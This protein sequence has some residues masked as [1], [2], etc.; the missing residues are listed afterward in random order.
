M[1]TSTTTSVTSLSSKNENNKKRN[2]QEDTVNG[3]KKRKIDE[4]KLITLFVK[5]GDDGSPTLVDV[6]LEGKRYIGH[7]HNYLLDALQISVSPVDVKFRDGTTGVY[8]DNTMPLSTALSNNV[9]YE[10]ITLVCVMD[11][12]IVTGTSMV[13]ENR[14]LHDENKVSGKWRHT[15]FGRDSPSTTT[16]RQSC[17]CR[18]LVPM[19]VRGG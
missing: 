1:N 16:P 5:V 13:S 18:M 14:R 19:H 15:S 2:D 8:L 9:L 10:G 12:R 4:D 7:I 17:R 3:D 11:S 6:P